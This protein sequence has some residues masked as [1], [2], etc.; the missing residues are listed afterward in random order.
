M[1]N[2]TNACGC[3]CN[4]NCNANNRNSNTYGRNYRANNVS[5]ANNSYE[6]RDHNHEFVTSTNYECDDNCNKHNHR[7][8]GVTGPAIRSGLSHVHKIEACTDTFCDH[9]H[10]ICDTTGPAIFISNEKHVHLVKGVT[11]CDDCHDHEYY[12]TTLIEDPSN[13]PCDERR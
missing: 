5:P 10:K 12:F 7:I 3:N 9:N 13:V 1:R 8:A 4:C 11:S 6:N 2:N